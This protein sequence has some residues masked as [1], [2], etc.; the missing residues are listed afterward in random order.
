MNLFRKKSIHDIL[1]Q[2]KEGDESV[3][4]NILNGF[5]KQKNLPISS[6]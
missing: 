2:V 6:V 5:F 3:H 1:Q 4:G